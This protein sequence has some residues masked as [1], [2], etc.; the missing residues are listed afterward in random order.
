LSNVIKLTD[1]KKARAQV[2]EQANAFLARLDAG[3][4]ADDIQRIESWLAESHLHREVF[5]EMAK[6]W[7][8]MT[9]LSSLSEVFPLEE[10]SAHAV[11]R[12]YIRSLATACALMVVAIGSWLVLDRTG[13]EIEDGLIYQHHVT[14]I[15]EQ[16]TIV[17]PDNSELILNTNTEIEVSFS[18][19]ARNIFLRQGEG[20][21]TVTKDPSRPFRVYAGKR[22]V[23][24]VG[25]AFTVQHT[26]PDNV[27]VVVKEGRVNFLRL[28]DIQ[29]PQTLPR[30]IDDVL[31]RAESVSLAAGELAAA[32]ADQPAAVQKI[33]I[34]QDEIEVKLAW[35]HGMLLF[36]GTPL[37]DVLKEMSRYTTISIEADET[38][39]A[40]PVEAY[41]RAGDIDG[42]IVLM[43]KNVEGVEALQVDADHIRL[44]REI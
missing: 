10:Y 6:L 35:T 34:Q 16:T 27:E 21:F 42:L 4:S 12:K 2:R 44:Y 25:T 36:Q 26:Q 15:G 43:K 28:S 38:I 37:E 33:Q 17:L 5:Q 1:A 40:I 31:Y 18:P 11:R 8:D 20:F 24:A 29:D 13:G 23:E 9:V 41:L 39:K 22:M 30:N 14:A 7:D 19:S 3:A 32:L